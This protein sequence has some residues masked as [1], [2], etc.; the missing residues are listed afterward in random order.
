VARAVTAE[1][2][3]GRRNLAAQLSLGALGA[4]LVLLVSLAW[5]TGAAYLL[6]RLNLPSPVQLAAVDALHVYVGIASIAFFAAK[7]ARVG[8][9]QQVDGVPDLLLWH[10]WVSWS[11]LVL[12]SG[13]Y[14][15]GVALLIPFPAD[16]RQ[17][18][19]NA[20]LLLSVWAAV[21]TTLHA[22]HHRRWALPFVPRLPR[23]IPRRFLVAVAVA[24]VPAAAFVVTP[25][26]MS[27]L[28]QV[29]AGNTWAA[30]ALRG[31]FLDRME[32]TADGQTL[33][34]GGEGL[35]ARSV[36]GGSWHRITFPSD[37]IL[38]LATPKGPVAV[39]VGTG[40]GLYASATVDGPYRRLLFPA[41]EVHGIAVDP[42]DSNVI[43]ASS[44]Q[45]FWRSTDAAAHWTNE[46]AGIEAP[47][48]AWAIAFFDGTVFASDVNGVY[49]WT[50]STWEQSSGQRAVVSLDPTSDGRLFASSMGQGVK[51]FSNGGWQSSDSGLAANHGGVRV[52][53]V[54]SITAVPGGRTYA[55]MMLDGTATSID[56]GQAW[57]RITAGLPLGAVWRI[58]PVDSG[59][60]AATD[61]GVYA[62]RLPVV[63]SP[64]I[65]WWLALIATAV[66]FG[67][68]AV[69]LAA[70]PA[71]SGRVLRH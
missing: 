52:I 38:G 20:H 25:R 1:Q 24:I 41:R 37:L 45:G 54:D 62:Y 14:L 61:H 10:R 33:V 40:T 31:V 3:R 13:V 49:R 2:A 29:S 55:A 66:L 71:R 32:R 58:L 56:L 63:E 59:L 6:V 4:S 28:A 42:L 43:W 19:A 57:T 46:S 35:Y 16:G 15:T 53:H 39:Y 30:S 50:G 5:L 18:L 36:R 60:V 26:A 12:Y 34:A 23:L 68:T 21:P 69:G 27:L 47:P 11:L 48:T 22:W 51:V 7:V 64:G 67:A 9:R 8:F 70:L 65:V 44:R 17:S